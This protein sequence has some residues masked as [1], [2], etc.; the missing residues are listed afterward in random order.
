MPLAEVTPCG[1]SPLAGIREIGAIAWASP[2]P[3]TPFDTGAAD[4][5][6]GAEVPEAEGP[7]DE[8]LAIDCG[9]IADVAEIS[10]VEAVSMAGPWT[11]PEAVADGTAATLK[12]EPGALPETMGPSGAAGV[13]TPPPREVL[14]LEAGVELLP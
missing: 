8:L 10:T 5:A 14:A 4:G 1:R 6:L 13:V 9:P 12:T 11:M 7:D 2:G 3:T